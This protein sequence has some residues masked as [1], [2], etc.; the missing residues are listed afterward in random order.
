MSVY[1]LPFCY[2]CGYPYKDGKPQCGCCSLEQDTQED[3]DNHAVE[4]Q[5]NNALPP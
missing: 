3:R 2:V 5:I 4:G 1:D